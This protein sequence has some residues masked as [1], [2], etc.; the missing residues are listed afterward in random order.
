MPKAA[1]SAEQNTIRSLADLVA[2]V[3]VINAALRL[4]CWWR[5]QSDVQWQLVPQA[6]RSRPDSFREDSVIAL[7]KQHAPARHP[8]CPGPD[9]RFGWLLLM[10]HYRAPTRLL[11]WSESP[12]VAAY[13][14]VVDC[15]DK[16]GALWC[17]NPYE[18]NNRAA[19]RGTVFH[20]GHELIGQFLDGAVDVAAGTVRP[21]E[22][23]IA[24]APDHIDSRLMTQQSTFTIHANG[25]PLER[26]LKS[27]TRALQQL[28]IP[29]ETKLTIRHQLDLAGIRRANLFP[30]LQSLAQELTDYKYGSYRP[31]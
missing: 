21:L 6:L 18:L 22:G 11:D 15:P 3:A 10:Q 28:L 26:F 5:G 31:G 9:D 12:L 4:K 14:A 24:V 8:N 7:F 23:A 2:S 1:R 27:N 30:D 13:F 29:A 20:A 19:G 17:L 16:D 25:K